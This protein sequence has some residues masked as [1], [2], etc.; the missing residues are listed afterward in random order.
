MG[1]GGETFPDMTYLCDE[2]RFPMNNR[3]IQNAKNSSKKFIATFFV[4]FVVAKS[5]KF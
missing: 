1:G 3:S 4:S 2:S 5:V